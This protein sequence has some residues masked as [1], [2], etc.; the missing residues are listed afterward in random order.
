MA[1]RKLEYT[2]F[3]RRFTRRTGAL[4]LMADLGAA[5]AAPGQVRMLG[6]GNPA[7]IPRMEQVYRE[8][9]ARIAG[10]AAAFARMAGQYAPPEGD[11]RFRTAVAASLQ[12]RFGWPLSH[13]NVALTAGSQ[14]AFFLLFNLFG[15]CGTHGR[16]RILLPV[17]P[18]Y[19]GYADLGLEDGLFSSSRPAIE[20]REPPFFKYRIDFDALPLD[21]E[22]SAI[23][24]SRPTNP[25]GN[26]LGDE[27]IARLDGLARAR[28]I[29]L[30]I[31]SAYGLPFP[32]IQFVEAAPAWNDNVILCLS[33]SKIGL[34][35]LRTGIVV[36]REEIIEA[37]AA[38]T[39][40]VSLAPNNAGAAL[41]ERLVASGELI[42]LS[43]T[44]IRPFYRERMEQAVQWLREACD[45]L[46]L[47]LHQPEGAFFLW[48]WF[49]GLPIPSQELYRRLKARGVIVLSGHHFFPGLDGAWPHR[50][51]C[52][53]MSYAQEPEVVS[54]GIRLIAE[55]VRRAYGEAG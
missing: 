30:I 27:E 8:E 41:A 38:M 40:V 43:E 13:R 18:E 2:D 29:P 51:E 10:D 45:G 46:P 25:T 19:V 11:I 22:V 33:L 49:E 47:R 35:G 3:G 14:T 54:Q 48:L 17:T 7:R 12:Q 20:L 32:A 28:G 42:G 9:L 1:G 4:E 5:L 50:E 21:D 55:E 37:L 52:L 23:C 24:A 53:R 36:A 31:D 44:V 39:A 15:G 34:P 16:R 6:G 26:V